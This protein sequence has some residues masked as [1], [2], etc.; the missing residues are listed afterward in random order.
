MIFLNFYPTK[1]YSGPLSTGQV[2]HLCLPVTVPPIILA[3]NLVMGELLITIPHSL[4]PK[5]SCYPV[6]KGADFLGP[7]QVGF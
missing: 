2:N 4:F 7:G 1:I 6:K 3:A 5:L